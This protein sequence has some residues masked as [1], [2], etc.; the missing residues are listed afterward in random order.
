M[1]SPATVPSTTTLGA[2]QIEAV[3]MQSGSAA[4]PYAPVVEDTQN[5]Q[6]GE[7]LEF[8]VVAYD[9]AGGRHIL[10]ASD[11]RWTDTANQYG[12]LDPNSGLFSVGTAAM[13]NR[14]LVNATLTSTGATVAAWYLVNPNQARIIGKVVA[15]NTN[16]PLRGIEIDFFDST[17][18]QTA[19]V[20]SS[21][22]G[23]FRASAKLTTVQFTVNP[24]SIPSTFW[25][26]FSYGQNPAYISSPSTQQPTLLYDAGSDTC[27]AAFQTLYSRSGSQLGNALTI[28]E[29]FMFAPTQPSTLLEPVT[30][31]NPSDPNLIV[32]SSK[33]TYQTRPTS[34]G[35]TG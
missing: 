1:Q 20:V 8:Q 29:N 19:S 26:Q 11:W 31:A 3:I 23:T 4:D 6:V 28:G 7:L 27:M 10:P 25:Q 35:C 30:P 34:N 17:L 22:D 21:Y 32:I 13:A 12:T 2:P 16:G 33:A 14:G 9:A 18:T 15:S 5:I 24:D